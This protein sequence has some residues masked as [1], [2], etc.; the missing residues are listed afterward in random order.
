MKSHNE[1]KQVNVWCLAYAEFSQFLEPMK[2]KLIGSFKLVPRTDTGIFAEK[3]TVCWENL[4]QGT[5]Q[6]SRVTLEEAVPVA[7]MRSRSQ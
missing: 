2:R 7:F 5:R 1:E 4:A 6:L 3:A